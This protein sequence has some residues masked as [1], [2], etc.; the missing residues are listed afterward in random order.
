MLKSAFGPMAPPPGLG[1][2]V[3][4]AGGIGVTYVGHA[5]VL[6]QL[7]T[8]TLLTDPVYSDRLMVPRRLVAPG[9]ALDALPKLDVVLV[10]HGHMDHLDVPTHRML[11]KND[12]VVVVA[13]GLTDLVTGCGYKEIVELRWH[14][15]TTIGDV[16]I[17]SLPV[18]HWGT[19]AIV[20]DRRGY[21]GFLLEH[22]DGSV[23]FPGDTA[24]EP[25]FRDYG[26]RHD[27]DVALLPIGAYS[28][29]PFRAHHMNPEDALTA[30]VN[31]NARWLVPIHWGTFVISAEP[32]EEPVDWLLELAGA[33]GLAERIAVL[34]H[35]ESRRFAR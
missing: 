26:E 1:K 21:T 7:G 31:L 15:S 16:R 12:T 22:P 13:K 10:S 24:H 33:R 17:T 23:F 14:E 27:V 30:L 34:R 29:P 25:R 32:V 19:R 8:T 5:T 4:P 28:P 18:N 11:P 20:P 35:G 3:D 9:V 6:L 2:P